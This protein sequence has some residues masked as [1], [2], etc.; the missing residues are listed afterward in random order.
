MNIHVSAPAP[1]NEGSN[2]MYMENRFSNTS[3][4]GINVDY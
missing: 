2:P 4:R 1:V 3:Q